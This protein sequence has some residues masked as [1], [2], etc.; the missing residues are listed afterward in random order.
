MIFF[1]L[2]RLVYSRPIFSPS[3]VCHK[4]TKES[5][6]TIRS[7]SEHNPGG[8][9]WEEGEDGGEYEIRRPQR[10][11]GEGEKLCRNHDEKG[12]QNSTLGKG[13]DGIGIGYA[14]LWRGRVMGAGAAATRQPLWVSPLCRTLYIHSSVWRRHTT[15]KTRARKGTTRGPSTT[16]LR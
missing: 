7:N 5:L 13:R 3:L 10:K 8:G 15:L 9:D 11:R 4:N 14:L 16:C 2:P 12:L 6:A 1:Q